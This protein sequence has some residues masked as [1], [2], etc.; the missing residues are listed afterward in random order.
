[1]GRGSVNENLSQCNDKNKNKKESDNKSKTISRRISNR[2]NVGEKKYVSSRKTNKIINGSGTIGI[3]KD[4]LSCKLINARSIVNKREEL[5]LYVNEENIDII[6]ITETWLNELILDSEV[7]LEGYTLLRKDRSNG[8]KTRGGGVAFYVKDSISVSV[9]D[10][11]SSDLFPE[12]LFC[13]IEC[14]GVRTLLGIC[15][16]APD[17]STDSD[18]ELYRLIGQASEDNCVIMGDFNFPELCWSKIDTLSDEHPFI[19]CI[20]NSFMHQVV[21]EPTRGRNFLDLVLCSDETLVENLIVREP[22]GTSDH[23]LVEFDLIAIKSKL[24]SS[25][26]VYNYFKA[27][28]KAL[29]EAFSVRHNSV[30]TENIDEKWCKIKKDLLTVRDEFVPKTCKSKKKGAWITNN[31][32]KYRRAKIKAW[33]KYVKSGKSNQV[34]E[35]YKKKLNR[36]VKENNKAKMEFETR[37]AKNIKNDSK[38]F[39]S[40]VRSKQR[41]KIRVGPIKDKSGKLILED[42]VSA[43][44]FNEYFASVFTVEDISNIPTPVQLFKGNSSDS[45]SKIEISEELVYSKLSKLKVSKSPGP[46][47]IHPKILYGLRHELI[48][49]LTKLFQLSID[50]GSVPQEWKDA[51]VSPLFKK[52]KKDKPENYR[53]V[54]LTSIVGKMLESIIKDKIVEHLEKFKLINTSQHGFSKGKSCLTNLLEF[55][56]TVT[57][58]LDDGEPVDLVYLDFAK[59]FDKV[60]YTRLF[61]KIEAHGIS[62]LV[63]K[64]V[65]NWLDNRRQKVGVNQQDSEWRAVTSGVPQGSVLG[66]VLFLIYIN[67]ID[68][69]LVSKLLKFA[70]DSKMCKNVQKTN[71]FEL[72]QQDLDRLHEWSKDWQMQ[73]NTDKCSVIH[74]GS[75]N[76]K[77]NYKLGDVVLRS[78]DSERDLGVIV[79]S[80]MKFSEQCNKAVKSANSTLGLI[81]RTIKNKKRAIIVK[82][83]KA[84]VRPKLEY[85][86]QAWRPYLRKDI[87]SLEQVQHRATKMIIECRNQ[88]Y[89]SRLVSTGLTTLEVRR[90]R[91]DL[92]ELFKLIK[93]IDKVDYKKFFQLANND[94]TRGHKYKIV[95]LR[96]RLEIRKHFFSQRVV[97]NWNSLPSY[98]VEAESVNSF[99]NRIDKYYKND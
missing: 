94:R 47:E 97:N 46:D 30:D 59:A 37:L 69:N 45:L 44:V 96:S 41:N 56:E 80:S 29:A 65:K 92:I 76:S 84:L 48:K 62:G 26:M 54:S 58:Y 4:R 86:V 83:Y 89:E 74:V 49:P 87:D 32:R 18:K 42:K 52:G 21:D 68:S 53:P 11:F 31:V 35:E 43:N 22:F 17:S 85:C 64:W 6:G 15:Y 79:D 14:S 61:K 57:Q 19:S 98:V 60:P 91:G 40:Y 7:E 88:D 20:N 75:G 99:K 71:D 66:P 67:D 72:L 2:N 36:S 63:L 12:C 5:E 82:L 28:Y 3:G 77:H 34:Y 13:S 9:R 38:S 39:F 93:G 95:K 90:D 50:L 27:D 1:M 23:C 55:F 8:V 33:N 24:E 81:K 51:R 78:S 70:D 16:R 25:S 73:F 10:E